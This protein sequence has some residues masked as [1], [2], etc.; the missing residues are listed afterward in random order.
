M[1]ARARDVSQVDDIDELCAKM[2]QQCSQK[3]FSSCGGAIFLLRWHSTSAIVTVLAVLRLLLELLLLE[4]L[5]DIALAGE[6]Y[7][8][9]TDGALGGVT[10]L[11]GWARSAALE[12]HVNLKPLGARSFHAVAVGVQPQLAGAAAHSDRVP[13]MDGGVAAVA[14][15]G[16]LARLCGPGG[17]LREKL[18]SLRDPGPLAA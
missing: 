16:V 5:R 17:H 10:D 11:M 13:L 1:P 14:Q 3:G 2:L 4:G 15:G 7:G 9:A 18:R 12:M 6:V 8:V